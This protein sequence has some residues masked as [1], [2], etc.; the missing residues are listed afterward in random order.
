MAS[1][2]TAEKNKKQLKTKHFWRVWLL[3]NEIFTMAEYV[4]NSNFDFFDWIMTDS[5]FTTYIQPL[6]TS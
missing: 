4:S 2:S 6:Y 5:Y 3:M 1:C